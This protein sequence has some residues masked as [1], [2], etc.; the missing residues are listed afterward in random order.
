M[1]SFAPLEHHCITIESFLCHLSSEPFLGSHFFMRCYILLFKLCIFCV[2]S[3]VS[4]FASDKNMRSI[5]NKWKRKEKKNQNQFS[6]HAHR[7]RLAH[8]N[9]S[10]FFCFN[11]REIV[12]LNSTVEFLERC[13]VVIHSNW[14]RVWIYCVAHIQQRSNRF[15][16]SDQSFFWLPLVL[17][18]LLRFVSFTN[19][20]FDF[21]IWNFIF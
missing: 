12:H 10:L 8:K 3:L 17:L 5:E 18:L 20:L 7:R 21:H 15:H 1:D 4:L 9:H 11:S 2:H 19:L 14:N 16:S 6:F 13:A